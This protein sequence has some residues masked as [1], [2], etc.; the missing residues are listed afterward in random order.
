MRRRDCQEVT[1]DKQ[2]FTVGVRHAILPVATMQVTGTSPLE[3]LAAAVDS[4]AR[5]ALHTLNLTTGSD[6][7]P[8][9]RKRDRSSCTPPSPG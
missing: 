2:S 9:F 8:G 1:A 5:A 4:A 7:P 6:T 3:V